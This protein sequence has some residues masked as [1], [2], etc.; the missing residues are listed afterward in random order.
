MSNSPTANPN[1]V[2]FG[3]SNLRTIEQSPFY[4]VIWSSLTS[5]QFYKDFS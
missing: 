5:T 2:T 1:P 4:L 3:L